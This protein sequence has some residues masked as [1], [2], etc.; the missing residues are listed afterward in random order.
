MYPSSLI[1]QRTVRTILWEGPKYFLEHMYSL[2]FQ[3]GMDDSKCALIYDSHC[4][5]CFTCTY[6]GQ[7]NN[8]LFDYR[9]KCKC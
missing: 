7:H 1:L 8:S 9:L 4:A 6:S 5:G 2:W 3:R